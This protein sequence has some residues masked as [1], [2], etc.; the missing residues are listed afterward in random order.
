MTRLT[1]ASYVKIALLVLLALVLCGGIVS[2]SNRCTSAFRAPVSFQN[3]AGVTT[4]E[5]GA[6]S[7]AGADVR[8]IAIA[9]AAGSASVTVCD[10]A[11]AGGE[12]VFTET[13]AGTRNLPLR[14]GCENGTLA[15]EYA[16]MRNFT[17]CSNLGSKHLDVKVPRSVAERLGF[18]ELDVA[19]GD[20]AV[21]GLTCD[22][23]SLG[24]AS[25][26]VEAANVTARVLKLDVASGNVTF[27][28]D[29]YDTVNANMGSGNMNI[30]TAHCPTYADLDMASGS[31]TFGL[32]ST[33]AFEVNFDALSG[34][35]D[36]DFAAR[37]GSAPGGSP[38]MGTTAVY[39]DAGVEV[40]GSFDVDMASGHLAFRMAK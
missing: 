20:Y 21:D 38:A 24:I 19:S 32:P 8:N 26:K 10:D 3:D 2:C 11:E 35:V 39:G 6:G 23:M 36:S 12:V 5:A 1:N 22:K 17:G 18:F 16:S 29:F 33:S 15:I 25:G 27:N 31:V 34:K 7:V 30:S 13:G 4:Q 37:G 14:W 9:W 40:T 28:G